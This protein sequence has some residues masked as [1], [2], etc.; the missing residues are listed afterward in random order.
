MTGVFFYVFIVILAAFAIH[1]Y[2]DS[3]RTDIRTKAMQDSLNN[4][5]KKENRRGCK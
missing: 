2:R 4:L 1:A 5:I 3:Q